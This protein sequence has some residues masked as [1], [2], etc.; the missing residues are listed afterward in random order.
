MRDNGFFWWNNMEKVRTILA[1][2]GEV[3]CEMYQ[4]TS[5]K[6]IRYDASV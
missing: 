4:M 2:D 1:F 3:N 6:L 5:E